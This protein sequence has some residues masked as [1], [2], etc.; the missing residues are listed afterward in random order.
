MGFYATTCPEVADLPSKN[1]VGGS[2]RSAATR[3]ER[4][5]PQPVETVSETTVTVTITVSGLS[6]WLSRDPVGENSGLNLFA[7]V[8]ND[9]VDYVDTDGMAKYQNGSRSDSK[10]RGGPHPG[11]PGKPTSPS[12]RSKRAVYECKGSAMRICFNQ[13]KVCKNKVGE[14]WGLGYSVAEAEDDTRRN[15]L[16]TL[17]FCDYECDDIGIGIDVKCH[18]TY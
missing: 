2:R 18:A 13:C 5:A 9:V 17:S 4:F 14:G 15:A 16:L 7:Y 8:D 3:A 6:F 11:T 12:G 10:P 1:R